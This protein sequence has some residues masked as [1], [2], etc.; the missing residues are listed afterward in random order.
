MVTTDLS[1]LF[2][3][4]TLRDGSGHPRGERLAGE[5]DWVGTA[6][7][8]GALYL[9][10]WYPGLT[11][12][13]GTGSWVVGDVYRLRDPGE[14]LRWLDEY[15]GCAG[16]SPEYERI[17]HP[18]RLLAES[19]DLEVWVYRFLGPLERARMIPGGDFLR[20]DEALP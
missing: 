4:G 17:R 7:V 1:L 11:L 5:A 6:S 14:S 2:V 3:Y 8:E 20:R 12:T 18:V 19:L 9:I 10:S 16:E 13:P 15:E